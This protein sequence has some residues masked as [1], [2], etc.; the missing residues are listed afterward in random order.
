M[1]LAIQPFAGSLMLRISQKLVIGLFPLL[2]LAPGCSKENNVDQSEKTTNNLHTGI[3]GEDGGLIGSRD[4]LG[5]FVPKYALEGDV[6]VTL[7]TADA[8]ELTAP[9][10]LAGDVYSFEPHDAAFF[11]DVDIY[12]PRPDP[13]KMY[14]PQFSTD[15][16]NWTPVSGRIDYK[17]GSVH[18]TTITFSYFAL[19]E[20]ALPDTNP[21]GGGGGGLAGAAGASTGGNPTGGTTGAGGTTGVGDNCKVDDTAPLG[22]SDASG[23]LSSMTNTEQP[24]KAMD[25]LIAAM[26]LGGR[27]DVSLMLSD[28]PA[29]CG[30]A[31]AGGS[32]PKEVGHDPVGRAGST[33]LA[34]TFTIQGA[35]ASGNYPIME[36]TYHQFDGT[37]SHNPAPQPAMGFV[38]LTD[39]AA[40]RVTGTITLDDEST[41]RTFGGTFDLPRCPLPEAPASRCCPQ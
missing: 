40:D 33:A 38:E 37:C 4:E 26:D 12:L 7:R 18:F 27:L 20:Q 39:V 15:G 29:A 6:D 3:V 1:T 22:T 16:S 32:T 41:G 23:T 25:G 24:F 31:L 8:S 35:L 28:Q 14:S 17:K 36:A 34:V 9:P 30:A 10:G 13:S 11:T 21:G 19:V 5:V 2:L